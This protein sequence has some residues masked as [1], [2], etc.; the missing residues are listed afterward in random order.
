MNNS[1]IKKTFRKIFQLEELALLLA[2]IVLCA[3][4]SIL[5]PT[6]VSKTNV[7]NILR[8]V[9]MNAIT[10]YGIAMLMLLGEIDL[11]TGSAQALV[12]IV[13]ISILNA[14]QSPFLAIVC[15]LLFGAFLGLVIGFLTVKLKLISFIVTLGMQTIL[16]GAAM[17]VTNAQSIRIQVP[18]YGNL[19]TGYFLGI[20]IPVILMIVLFFVVNYVLT[21]T[22]FGRQIFAIGGNR[23]AAK[24]AG[25]K[26]DRVRF[27]VF[28]ISGMLTALS[29][30]ILSGRLDS[31]QPNAG[32]GFETKVIS[33][34][35]LGGV[36]MSG[37]RGKLTGVMIGM[38]LLGVL[39]NG[40]TLLQVSSF[41]QDICTGAITIL[42]VYIDAT[43]RA[44]AARK[45]NQSAITTK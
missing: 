30:M 17:V 5:T 31:A 38:L 12:A 29:A 9:S 39:S 4:M 40:L 33:A 21:K 7:L 26:V 16:R 19:G 35:V 25:L 1:S 11:S 10:G 22:S 43:R 13:A 24:L 14:T 28:I 6:F 15:G 20:P 42:A 8:Q 2:L 32:I 37:G 27:I 3:V 45:L 18:G 44:S 23:E 36:S 41:W 34:V